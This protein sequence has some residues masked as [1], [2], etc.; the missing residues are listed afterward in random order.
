M[1]AYAGSRE[2]QALIV[3]PI[4]LLVT[5][6]K[7][8]ARHG[9]MIRERGHVPVQAEYFDRS[10]L[11]HYVE[12]VLVSPGLSEE[13]RLHADRVCKETGFEAAGERSYRRKKV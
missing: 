12:K 8:E 1:N 2:V 9:W 11:I 3:H 7:E 6:E 5:T 10:S 4:T 13:E